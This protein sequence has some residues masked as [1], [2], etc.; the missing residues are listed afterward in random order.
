MTIVPPVLVFGS[1]HKFLLFSLL[2]KKKLFSGEFIGM[3]DKNNDPIHEG[4][5]VKLYYKGEVV[6]CKIV[7]VSDWAMFCLEWPD[8]YRN[9]FPMNPEKY[10]IVK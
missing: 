7:Y 8:G 1:P 4:H 2:M 10:E 5:Q 6:T 3:Y 9:K